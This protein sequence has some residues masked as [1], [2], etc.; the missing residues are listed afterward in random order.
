[1]RGQTVHNTL[2]HA[3]L[4]AGFLEID[5]W[6]ASKLNVALI[7][8]LLFYFQ[9]VF[10]IS[11]SNMSP[12]TYKY[13]YQWL[14]TCISTYTDENIFISCQIHWTIEYILFIKYLFPS[15]NVI[16]IFFLEINAFHFIYILYTQL[17]FFLH[18]YHLFCFSIMEL[19]ARAF[20]KSPAMIFSSDKW[21]STMP[22]SI[23]HVSI[24]FHRLL[25]C[26]Q[27][28]SICSTEST[29]SRHITHK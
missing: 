21:E 25:V 28:K 19:M 17:L 6:M 29:S 9:I 27:C 4:A 5:V 12:S 7:R 18:T 26:S 20:S 3:C 14:Y 11:F 10:F 8:K 23:I 22:N 24:A 16:T 15:F 1:M 13:D 2:P